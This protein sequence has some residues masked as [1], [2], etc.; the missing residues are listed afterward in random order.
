[1]VIENKQSNTFINVKSKL[2]NNWKYITII[3]VVFFMLFIF[4]QIYNYLQLQDLKK[5]S[6]VFFSSI[7]DQKNIEIELN[8]IKNKNNIYSTLSKLKLIQKS[9][10]N[11]NFELSNNLY[12]ELLNSSKLNNIYKSSIAMHASYTMIN[13]SYEENTNNYI[14][15]INFYINQIDENLNSFTSQKKELEYIL[16]VT[17]I[18]LNNYSYE[19]NTQALDLYNEIFNSSIISSSVKER[20]KKIHEFQLYK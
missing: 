17:E 13:A 15:D 6:I 16:M 19:N 18:D 4:F 1:M 10:D 3:A 12:K 5:T 11:K 9:N 2:Q 14:K 20:V 7:N 8:N